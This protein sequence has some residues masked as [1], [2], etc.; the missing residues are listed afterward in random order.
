MA[1][2]E[3]PPYLTV[4]TDV[5]A[6]YKGAFCEAKI[7]DVNKHVKLRVLFEGSNGTCLIHDTDIKAGSTLETGT[8]IEAKHPE[9]KQKTYLQATIT[10]ILD[11]SRYTV[12]FDDGDQCVLRR[13]SL[14]LK[15]GKHFAESETLDQLPLTNP[16]HF[17]N[18]VKVGAVEQ[19]NNSTTPPQSTVTKRPSIHQLKNDK[20]LKGKTSS[21]T[22]SSS[23][24]SEDNKSINESNNNN[25][26]SRK[27]QHSQVEYNNDSIKKLKK[28][29]NTTG[30]VNNA[31]PTPNSGRRGATKGRKRRE[32]INNGSKY[33]T[34]DR[35]DNSIDSNPESG[36]ASASE[37]NI[38]FDSIEIGV[39][40]MVQYGKGKIQNVYEAKVNRMET[41]SAGRTR[42][43]VHYTGWNN[44][45]DEWINKDR[46]L[47][48]V[49]EKE[50]GSKDSRSNQLDGQNSTTTG[51]GSTASSS[52]S[53]S[54]TT[55]STRDK[56]KEKD[57][58]KEKEK[59]EKEKAKEKEK[60]KDREF[61]EKERELPAK[62]RRNK[63][64]EATS[65][66]TTATTT[67]TSS[68][69]QSNA[70]VNL[71]ST[72]VSVDTCKLNNEPQHTSNKS[73]TTNHSEAKATRDK[74]RSEKEKEKERKE[75]E[76]EKEREKEKD[77]EK[78]KLKEKVKEKE[79]PKEKDKEIKEKER[80]VPTKTRRAKLA[81][82]TSI[83]TSTTT[84][85]PT[86]TTTTAPPP[87]QPTTA[88]AAATTTTTSTPSTA[89]TPIPTPTPAPSAP[90]QTTTTLTT[91]PTLTTT[92]TTTSTSLALATIT[93]TTVTATSSPISTITSADTPRTVNSPK[94]KPKRDNELQ[95]ASIKLET[96]N[97]AETKANI[98]ISSM[99]KELDNQV[100]RVSEE[101]DLMNQQHQHAVMLIRSIPTPTLPII[102][103]SASALSTTTEIY[104]NDTDLVVV[105]E[106]SNTA[107]DLEDK[108]SSLMSSIENSNIPAMS[109]RPIYKFCEGID[110]SDCDKKI[111]LLQERILA[112][113]QTY[114]SLKT[115]LAD[116]DRR[117][118][119]PR[120]ERSNTG[121][122]LSC[123]LVCRN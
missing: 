12:V 44:R 99:P 109:V 24:S 121:E 2:V 45:Y 67:T 114:I 64:I 22:N 104:D 88:A 119:R 29:R 75:K 4:G 20:P 52:I 90:P 8:K 71:Q 1:S 113:R 111:S 80:E 23:T 21:T 72:T 60:D 116:L 61:K 51:N 14:C 37:S 73:E 92:P 118:K 3:E 30:N 102:P 53:S 56:E 96:A 84:S 91:A 66:T 10:K 62:T 78:E 19:Q 54:S 9:K 83:T 110:E 7:T 59:V 79:K 100:I 112:L 25:N 48:I 15:S 55:I 26:N 74:E 77:R 11:H 103:S 49:T 18:P 40:L 107:D 120:T 68:S 93:T 97:K 105:T 115:E 16:E 31:T 50:N 123:G 13:N 43:F 28:E 17:G 82:A 57:K 85:T 63:Y 58:D 108:P 94:E 101:P 41:N 34:T 70:S 38:K 69:A 65:I 81:E 86:L 98:T 76:K 39:K 117:R 46:I 87:P 47:S 36:D 33:A 106:R 95:T 35:D 42:Y 89:I 6:K 122:H 5:S 32:S 27:R